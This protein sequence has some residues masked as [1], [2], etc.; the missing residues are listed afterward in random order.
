M[1]RYYKQTPT[2]HYPGSV[3]F[4]MFTADDIRKISVKQIITGLTFDKFG[5]PLSGGLYDPVL[6]KI[7]YSITV[8]SLQ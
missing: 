5:H 8:L 1:E 7:F 3:R 6:G 2:T 4:S